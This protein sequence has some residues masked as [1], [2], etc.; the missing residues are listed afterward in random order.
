MEGRTWEGLILMDRENLDSEHGRDEYRKEGVQETFQSLIT[1]TCISFTHEDGHF[2]STSSEGEE[3]VVSCIL[4]N[5]VEETHFKNTSCGGVKESEGEEKQMREG[6]NNKP[7]DRELFG[8]DD[9]FESSSDGEESV[10]GSGLKTEE[11]AEGTD[12]YSEDV[13]TVIETHYGEFYVDNTEDEDSVNADKTHHDQISQSV[14]DKDEKATTFSEAHRVPPKSCEAERL[15]FCRQCEEGPICCVDL[16]DGD[17][18]VTEEHTSGGREDYGKGEGPQGGKEV[19]AVD[20]LLGHGEEGEEER[21]DVR[22]ELVMGIGSQTGEQEHEQQQEQQE[23]QAKQMKKEDKQEE[24]QTGE[25]EDAEDYLTEDEESDDGSDSGGYSLDEA[26]SSSQSVEDISANE[27]QLYERES[28]TYYR[29]QEPLE[30]ILEI[31][32]EEG[33]DEGKHSHTQ[34]KTKALVSSEAPSGHGYGSEDEDTLCG[35]EEFSADSLEDCSDATQ[36]KTD[37]P[38][39]SKDKSSIVTPSECRDMKTQS[40]RAL[41]KTKNVREES[42]NTRKDKNKSSKS[43]STRVKGREVSDRD[44]L[45]CLTSEIEAYLKETTLLLESAASHCSPKKKDHCKETTTTTTTSDHTNMKGPEG[46]CTEETETTLDHAMTTTGFD[47]PPVPL[48]TSSKCIGG[49]DIHDHDP[50]SSPS[51][52]TITAMTPTD[53]P[54]PDT[55][56]T[57]QY[58]DSHIYTNITNTTNTTVASSP[59]ATSTV[60]STRNEATDRNLALL[61]RLW[62]PITSSLNNSFSSEGIESMSEGSSRDYVTA[63]SSFVTLEGDKSNIELSVE[64]E[65]SPHRSLPLSDVT[66]V[67]QTVRETR[68]MESQYFSLLEASIEAVDALEWEER[69]RAARVASPTFYV[70]S[71]RSEEDEYF[72]TSLENAGD[73]WLTMYDEP[74]ECLESPSLTQL[75][76]PL[77]E[78]NKEEE[79]TSKWDGIRS[80]LNPPP[81]PPPPP[82]FLLSSSP[83]SPFP[84][85]LSSPPPPP[86]PPPPR[87]SFKDLED[88]RIYY[89]L[90]GVALPFPSSFSPAHRPLPPPPPPSPPPRSSSMNV[91]E[92]EIYVNVL[93]S[94][95]SPYRPPPPRPPPPPPPRNPPPPSL[96][97]RPES[98]PS[99]VSLLASLENLCMTWDMKKRDR[100]GGNDREETRRA[101]DF[102]VK[103]RTSEVLTNSVNTADEGDLSSRDPLISE[104]RATRV[105][106]GPDVTSGVNTEKPN[107]K[108]THGSAASQPTRENVK[109]LHKI[110]VTN[111]IISSQV[112]ISAKLEEIFRDA[113]REMRTLTNKQALQTPTRPEA[114]CRKDEDKNTIREE[115]NEYLNERLQEARDLQ[116]QL[117]D[118]LSGMD[119]M[120]EEHLGKLSTLNEEH[121]THGTGA[122]RGTQTKTQSS[123]RTAFQDILN[124]SEDLKHICMFHVN[125]TE[126]GEYRLSDITS[127]TTSFTPPPA[128]IHSPSFN[129][130]GTEETTPKLLNTPVGDSVRKGGYEMSSG[131]RGVTPIRQQPEGEAASHSVPEG[132]VVEDDFDDD[133]ARLLRF[134]QDLRAKNLQCYELP[135][136]YLTQLILYTADGGADGGA[137]GAAAGTLTTGTKTTRHDMGKATRPRQAASRLPDAAGSTSLPGQVPPPPPPLLCPG[138]LA[139]LRARTAGKTQ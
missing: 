8:E 25:D 49:A 55:T 81:R 114:A 75:S 110:G 33:D 97:P 132:G 30:V 92:E 137:D 98:P 22:G 112:R 109:S 130:R 31:L 72:F 91:V 35:S 102:E 100:E 68:E 128:S 116:K 133:S 65:P 125:K 47:S 90:E 9:H 119:A 89:E 99:T 77:S 15:S 3:S 62:A 71:Q 138:Y 45:K 83:Y 117:D 101:S 74:G 29:C 40:T 28:D 32:G 42:S 20:V 84:P 86:P 43:I 121:Q 4:K 88:E 76:S 24:S 48:R 95:A 131:V 118:I 27:T 124:I 59:T 26:L 111:K 34:H 129:Q 19:C 53:A 67:Y 2:E 82:G 37:R 51:L 93:P 87:S 126:G 108:V 61:E 64:R 104:A 54:S 123:E 21:N 136:K 5:D 18:R 1:K 103:K 39:M 52:Y 38:S 96:P 73:N 80:T 7:G 113:E 11:K 10:D 17:A 16:S 139:G 79:G 70:P 135:L 107:S 12:P 66:S 106:D 69:Q 94:S 6:R 63:N 13:D 134:L 85:R 78:D 58:G 50:C 46:S 105:H 44:K 14:A 56:S 36:S 127:S 57:S 115:E 41:L 122:Q 23:Q 120:Y 60:T